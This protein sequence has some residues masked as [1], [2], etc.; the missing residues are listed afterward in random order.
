MEDIKIELQ[1]FKNIE[2]GEVRSLLIDN[3]P[4]FVGKDVCKAFGDTNH[5]R[6]LSRIDNLDK[7][8]T[9]IKDNLGRTQKITVINESGLYALLFS[10]QPQKS[11]KNDGVQDAY[12][13]KTQERIEKLQKFKRWVTN[14]VLPTIRKT[15]GYVNNEA[16]FVESYFPEMDEVSKQFMINSLVQIKEK[17]KII[18]QQ[19]EEIAYKEDVIINLVDDVSLAEKRQVLNRVVRHNKANAQKRWNALYREF[20]NKYH[21]RVY[22]RMETYNKHNKP[23]CKNRVDYIDKVMGKL[24]EL[25]EIACKLYENDVKELVQEMYDLNNIKN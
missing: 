18:Q 22:S 20:D 15:G 10:M 13:T 3:E 17:N 16:M 1:V 24:P 4:Y 8:I 9:T 11:N 21:I 7:K 5:N 12:P 25:Y 23:K 6:S 2:F 19:K 14:D